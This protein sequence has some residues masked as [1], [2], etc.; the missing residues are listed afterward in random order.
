MTA[1]H[2][3]YQHSKPRNLERAKLTREQRLFLEKE[4]LEIFT[5]MVNGGQTFQAALSAVFLSGMNA[6]HN[7]RS[8]S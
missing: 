7:A 6:A 4:S 5:S 2:P 3:T 8:Q 1:L